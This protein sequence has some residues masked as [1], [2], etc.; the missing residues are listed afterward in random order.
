MSGTVRPG[1]CLYAEEHSSD[2]LWWT[3]SRTRTGIYNVVNTHILHP[4]SFT[5]NPKTQVLFE[6]KDAL[7]FRV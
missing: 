2:Q 1:L 3:L 5:F 6:L 7:S 4:N